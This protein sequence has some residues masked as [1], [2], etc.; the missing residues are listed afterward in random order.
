MLDNTKFDCLFDN[1]LAAW[2]IDS[3][4]IWFCNRVPVR[5]VLVRLRGPG[6]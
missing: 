6:G 1:I 3:V 5:G 4:Q 2:A